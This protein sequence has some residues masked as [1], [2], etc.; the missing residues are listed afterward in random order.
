M[1]GFRKSRLQD[2]QNQVKKSQ[3][4]WYFCGPW[5]AAA[6]GLSLKHREVPIL[7]ADQLPSRIP[8]I[9]EY[10]RNFF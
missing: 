2:W 4:N 1:M 5:I 10:W 6:S 8:L 7:Y 9:K 3:S